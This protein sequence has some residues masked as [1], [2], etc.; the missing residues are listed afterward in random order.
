MGDLC[1]W[2]LTSS[3]VHLKASNA[4]GMGGKSC[5]VWKPSQPPVT[6][7]SQTSEKSL[8]FPLFQ[9]SKLLSKHL[10]LYPQVSM[11]PNSYPGSSFHGRW[12][13]YRTQLVKCSEKLTVGYP[14]PFYASTIK[15]QGTKQKRGQKI[16]R[17]RGLGG[18]LL[19]PLD[20][21]ENLH[22]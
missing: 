19:S 4:G 5:L 9:A 18:S 12:D 7:E 14:S 11:A 13:Y 16:V 21:T 8:L 6:T 2:W 22:P 15:A 1:T 3:K 10:S 20:A 17:A